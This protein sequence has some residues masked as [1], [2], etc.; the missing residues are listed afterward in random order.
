M[1][2]APAPVWWYIQL[3]FQEPGRRMEGAAP[4]IEACDRLLSSVLRDRIRALTARGLIERFFFIRY[5]EEGYHLRLRIRGRQEWL[6]EQVQPAIEEAIV[7][8]CADHR[9]LLRLPDGAVTLDGL[10]RAGRVRWPRYEPEYAK[11]A[12]PEGVRKAEE[13]HQLSSELCWMILQAEAESRIGRAQFA[14]ELMMILLEQFSSDPQEQAFLLS[15]YTSYWLGMGEQGFTE[16]AA[17]M[18]A[19]YQRQKTRLSERFPATAHRGPAALERSWGARQP[20]LFEAWRRH[21]R[22][23]LDE[24]RE[25][26]LS[27]AL[28][29]PLA[30]HVREHADLLRSRPTIAR[31]PT[32]ALL[33]LPN[34][35][36]MLHNRLGLSPLQEIQMTYQLYRLLEDRHGLVAGAF[37]LVLEP[38]SLV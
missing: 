3:Y 17:Q 16:L 7:D 22:T 20:A 23:H 19:H 24:I 35:L 33:I 31:H 32:V 6:S 26:E 12:G 14:L 27:G 15:A 25:M 28:E 21:L 13:H 38:A 37:P 5:A 2:A 11:Y 1:S 30:G 34:Y 4:I 8:F 9:E 36:H 10:A 29:A 18:E